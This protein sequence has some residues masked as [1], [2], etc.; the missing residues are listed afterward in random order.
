MKGEQ[1]P[2]FDTASA[3]G[4]VFCFVLK[5]EERGCRTGVNT[6]LG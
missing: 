3:E 1:M 5:I 2:R 4:L 6:G